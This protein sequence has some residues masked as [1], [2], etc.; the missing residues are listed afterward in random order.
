MAEK[1]SVK[2]QWLSIQEAVKV[3]WE[4]G[5]ERS[6]K[7]IFYHVKVGNIKSKSIPRG[8]TT[9]HLVYRPSLEE[10]ANAIKR[11]EVYNKVGS[12]TSGV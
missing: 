3:L 6:E 5:V 1:L 11:G 12:G 8:R 2:T 4:M 9:R 7:S 10:Y